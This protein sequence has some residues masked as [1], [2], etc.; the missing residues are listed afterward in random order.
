MISQCNARFAKAS[1]HNAGLVC[2]FAGATSG[3]DAGMLERMALM[4]NG[5]AL[6]F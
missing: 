6:K 4:L 2:F 1:E 3:T 5:L